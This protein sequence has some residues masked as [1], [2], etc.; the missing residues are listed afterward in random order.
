MNELQQIFKNSTDAVFGIG[1]NGNICFINNSCETLLGY[2]EQEI[3]NKSCSSILHCRDMSGKRMCKD[4]PLKQIATG[5]LPFRDFDMVVKQKNGN[6]ILVNAGTSYT[7]VEAPKKTSNVDMVLS[8][9]RI[10]S[11]RL[12]QRM[13]NHKNTEATPTK[14]KNIL[15]K[16]EKEIL[17]LASEGVN[18][19]QIANQK[20]ISI[21]TVRNH[22]KNI[23]FKLDVHSRTEAVSIAL[24]QNFIE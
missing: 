1:A 24:R 8:L 12:L 7:P 20:C 11:L 2:S 5:I 18:T 15:T 21:E 23:L 13:S 10:N 14:G 4:C 22:F 9:R 19:L 16:R 3:R 17:T 6:T